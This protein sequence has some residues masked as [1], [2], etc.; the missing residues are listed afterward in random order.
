MMEQEIYQLEN[1]RNNSH[2]IFRV[3]EIRLVCKCT[4]RLKN[5]RNMRKKGKKNEKRKKNINK[6]K[7]KKNKGVIRKIGEKGEK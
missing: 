4:R 7:K 2:A 5:K 3:M 1:I 6:V